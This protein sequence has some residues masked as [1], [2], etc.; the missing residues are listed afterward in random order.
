M[1]DVFVT[2]FAPSPTGYLHIGHAYSA[3]TA[4]HTAIAAGGRFILRME[5]IDVGRCKPEFEEAIYEDLAWL[6][7]EWETPVRR[8]SEHLAD[9]AN[10]L[11]RLDS[12]GLTY[13]CFCTRSDIRA[14]LWRIDGAPHGNAGPVYPGTCRDLPDHDRRARVA[15]GEEHAIRL[16]MAEAVSRTGAVIWRDLDR[17]AITGDPMSH[18]DFVL[19]RKD[20]PTSY[21]LAVTIDDALQGIT[22]VTRGADLVDFT[23]IHRVLQDLLGLA[24]PQ[25]RHH[26][27]L[28]D[29]NGRRY[30]KRDRSLTIRALRAAGLTPEE[31]KGMAGF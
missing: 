16:R 31:V 14:E 25:Y 21:H 9:Y 11:A 17:G 22:L 6:G 1:S 30:A 15:A 3:L 5:D 26:T 2:R 23:D 29:A 27:L 7:I 12:L 20:I 18:G 28:T 8:Q 24:A 19:A 13:P 10:A 4:W